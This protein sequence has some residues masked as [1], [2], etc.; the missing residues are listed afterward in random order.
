METLFKFDMPNFFFVFEYIQITLTFR[1]YLFSLDPL[2][3][4]KPLQEAWSFEY[5]NFGTFLES[6]HLA[7]KLIL[8]NII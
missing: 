6:F 2:L 7:S 3:P 4:N 8:F 5:P 1:F